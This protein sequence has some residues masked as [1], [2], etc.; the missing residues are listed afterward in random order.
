MKKQMIDDI[1][2]WAGKR[3]QQWAKDVFDRFQ[4]ADIPLDISVAELGAFMT[5]MAARFVAV[6]NIPEKEAA[7]VFGALIM[8][9]RNELKQMEKE[10]NDGP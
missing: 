9:A 1:T 8:K 4:I 6:T 10:M 7:A 3:L 2:T 5:A